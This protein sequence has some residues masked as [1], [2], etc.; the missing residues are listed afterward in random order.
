MMGSKAFESPLISHAR[1][2]ALYRALV[3][4]RALGG[5]RSP[6]TK[7]FEACWVA[8]A[9][10]LKGGD[11][12]SAAGGGWLLD[13]V[14]RVGA[15]D[16]AKAGSSIEVR[17]GLKDAA[18]E[19]TTGISAIDRMLCAVGMAI[20]AKA[21]LGVV[22]AYVGVDELTPAEWK[23]L[24]TVANEGDLPLIIT[25][26]PGKTDVSAIAKRVGPMPV[27]PVDAGDVV[28]LYRVAQETIVRARADGGV[29]VIECVACGVDPVK[30]MG[31]QLVKK[32]IC[33][34]KWV[35]GVEPAFRKVVGPS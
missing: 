6:W 33:T 5:R 24:L 18:A 4:S 26:L 27:I 10:D 29:A 31:A 16:T 25:A 13:Y 1:M 9:I 21:T 22:M 2:R 3:E 12:T 8:T 19:K 30:L 14:R 17:R 23:R 11:F 34:A 20:A 32:K 28:A 35:A 15:R 7:N